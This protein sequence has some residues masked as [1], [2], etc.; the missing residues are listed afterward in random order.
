MKSA[1]LPVAMLHAAA[2]FTSPDPVKQT[3]TGILVRLADDGGVIISSTDG[4]RAFRVTCPDP[5]WRC[6]QALLLSGKAFKKRI[7]YARI[8][9]FETPFSNAAIYGGKK[10]AEYMQSL[11]ATWQ[12]ELEGSKHNY[13]SVNPATLYPQADQLWPSQYGKEADTPIGF[14]A[15]YL[16]DFLAIVKLYSHTD[17]VVSERN[18]YNTPMIFSAEVDM[19]E[20]SVTMEYLLMPVVDQASRAPYESRGMAAVESEE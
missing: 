18:K 14:N 4:H 3:L 16:A 20:L 19:P 12:C 17:L 10:V 13:T 9:E 8:A 11:P 5:K 7:P 1:I 15:A 6:K 2:Q